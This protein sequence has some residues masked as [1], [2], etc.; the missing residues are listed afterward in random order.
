MENVSNDYNYGSASQLISTVNN[1][2]NTVLSCYLLLK[3]ITDIVINAGSEIRM[4][5]VDFFK[6]VI[7]RGD[8][9]SGFKSKCPV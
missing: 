6:T 3:Q 1:V 8:I 4:S 5:W 9:Y 2:E 7:S